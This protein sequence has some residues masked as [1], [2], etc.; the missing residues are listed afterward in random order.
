[1]RNEYNYDIEDKGRIYLIYEI[2]STRKRPDGELLYQVKI[3]ITTQEGESGLRSRLMAIKTAN[4]R[5]VEFR[6]TSP[7]IDTYY[8]QIEK[9][10]HEYLRKKGTHI[11]GEWFLL[12]ELEMNML[13]DIIEGNTDFDW[14]DK[15][16]ESLL[17]DFKGEL[18]GVVE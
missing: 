1:M 8:N 10:I 9:T 17:E 12:S 14:T 18:E 2:N 7:Y 3:G 4:P 6:Y 5:E 16:A 15:N 13:S 11:Q